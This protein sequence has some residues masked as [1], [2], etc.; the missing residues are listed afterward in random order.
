MLR[1]D[2]QKRSFFKSNTK[3]ESPVTLRLILKKPLAKRNVV[4]IQWMIIICQYE[5]EQSMRCRKFLLE[6]VATAQL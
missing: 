5:S 3:V 1:K 2:E 6:S 4:H